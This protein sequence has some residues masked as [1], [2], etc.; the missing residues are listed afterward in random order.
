VR[1]AILGRTGT[2]LRAAQLLVSS[3]FT[4]PLVGTCLPA[5]YDATTADDFA[6]LARAQG[7]EYFCDSRINSDEI[8]AVLRRANCDVALSLNWL[9]IMGAEACAAFPHGILNVHGGDLPRY[10]GNACANWAILNGESRVGL[11]VHRMEPAALDAGPILL[12]D[13]FP[14]DESTYIGDVYA[15]MESAVPELCLTAITRLR[16]GAARFVEQD[17]DPATWL[18]CY[19][20]R[21]EDALID[22]RHSA[23]AIHRLVRASSRP[24]DGALTYLEGVEP[25]RVWRAEIG[26]HAGDFLAVPGQVMARSELDLTIACGDGVLSITDIE[27]AGVRGAEARAR[28]GKSLRNR[29]T[30]PA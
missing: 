5:S 26:T 27:V 17:P 18:R 9:T 25:V 14:L 30:G 24:F 8:L 15:W 22:W 19:P 1:V 12:K 3:G 23:A 29:L 10:R 7:S 13:F 2:L 6:A 16:D 28:V 4:I 21:P 20:R 11:T